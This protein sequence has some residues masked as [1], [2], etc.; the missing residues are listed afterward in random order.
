MHM[1]VGSPVSVFCFSINGQKNK[2]GIS[3]VLKI[4][5]STMLFYFR[6][7]IRGF[8]RLYNH[9][10][11]IFWFFLWMQ[12]QIWFF[13]FFFKI[14]NSRFCS[15]NY[16]FGRPSRCFRFPSVVHG[17]LFSKVHGFFFRIVFEIF[18]SINAHGEKWHRAS[19]EHRWSIDGPQVGVPW[20]TDA[21]RWD[22]MVSQ[23]GSKS[24]T[25]PFFSNPGLSPPW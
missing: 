15:K 9:F 17:C 1:L 2:D 23:Y 8:F 19:V 22:P 21:H 13:K 25:L 18:I 3:C 5:T 10:W 24:V 20:T 4:S 12:D 6:W 7:T 11:R 14:K 16:V